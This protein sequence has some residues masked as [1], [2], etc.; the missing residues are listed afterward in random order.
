MKASIKKHRVARTNTS[1]KNPECKKKWIKKGT[2]IVIGI[3]VEAGKVV[4]R[5]GPFCS[6]D[7]HDEWEMWLVK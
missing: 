1:C 3:I 4:D 7:C 2:P 6:S 5:K